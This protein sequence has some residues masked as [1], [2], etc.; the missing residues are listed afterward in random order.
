MAMQMFKKR[1]NASPAASSFPSRLDGW[2]TMLDR[3]RMDECRDVD[4]LKRALRYG[5]ELSPIPK[6]TW[7]LAR[8]MSALTDDPWAKSVFARLSDVRCRQRQPSNEE[9]LPKLAQARATQP[10]PHRGA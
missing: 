2:L 3:V 8:A 7:H 10:P 4:L 1:G 9:F 5:L 6:E